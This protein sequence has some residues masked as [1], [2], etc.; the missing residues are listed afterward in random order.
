ME[1]RDPLLRIL[2]L[3]RLHYQS[4]VSQM[5]QAM[6]SLCS[7]LTRPPLGFGLR[8]KAQDGREE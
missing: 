2:S 8:N 4:I 1:G 6:G 7:V 3:T 5:W